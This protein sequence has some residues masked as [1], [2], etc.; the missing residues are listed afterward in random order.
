MKINTSKSIITILASTTLSTLAGSRPDAHAPIGVMGDHVHKKGEFMVSYRAMTMEMNQVYRGSSN[1]ALTAPNAS[2]GYMLAPSQMTMDMNMLG[3]M[4]A[5]SDKLTL[6]AMTSY[7]HNTMQ[8]QN[9][10]GV[11]VMSM[12]TSGVGDS[13]LAALYQVLSTK[14]HTGSTNAHVGLGV[15]LPTGD[16]DKKAPNGRVQPF[17]MQLGSGT[18]DLSPSITYNQYINQQW[19]WGAQA[20]ATFHTGRNDEGYRLGDNLNLST[21]VARNVN[22]SFSVSGRVN[23]KSWSGVDG[24]QTNGLH[25]MNPMMSAPADPNN[26]GGMRTDLYFG[27]NYIHESGI[28]LATEL[29]KTI[30][31][32]LQ[33]VQLGADWSLNFGAQFA[34]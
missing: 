31:Q 17:P 26:T 33:G 20:K 6:M 25:A 23:F 12:K 4:Y 15:S 28:R 19:S 9:M 2:Y 8:M 7:K 22:E 29:G 30:H 34:W 24:T 21:W 13:S 14:T 32:D 27:I 5:P 1:T 16:I 10:N 11:E 3:M 18:F